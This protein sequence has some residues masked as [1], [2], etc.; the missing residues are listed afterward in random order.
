MTSIS[1]S[2]TVQAWLKPAIVVLLVAA[3]LYSVGRNILP[4]LMKDQTVAVHDA[5]LFE[6][7]LNGMP[8]GRADQPAVQTSVLFWNTQHA[9]NPFSSKYDDSGSDKPMQPAG[10]RESAFASPPVLSGFVAGAHSRLAVLNGEIAAVGDSVAGYR[11]LAID[12]AGVRLQRGG[13]TLHLS[14]S[15]EW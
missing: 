6:D 10:N 2:A 1:N 11:V 7:G 5:G 15:L 8:S 12:P 14:L 4:L 3:A 9:R 13:Q